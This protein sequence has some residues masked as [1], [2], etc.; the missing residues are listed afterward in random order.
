[1]YNVTSVFELGDYVQC[2]FSVR[3]KRRESV[4]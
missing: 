4:T 2:D 1:M 3:V